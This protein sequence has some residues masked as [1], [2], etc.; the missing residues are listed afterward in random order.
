MFILIGYLAFH[1]GLTQAVFDAARKWCSQAPGGLAMLRCLQRQ[2]SLLYP[3]RPLRQQPYFHVLR[4]RR[5]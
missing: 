3:E 5:C 2:A 1:A 4:F